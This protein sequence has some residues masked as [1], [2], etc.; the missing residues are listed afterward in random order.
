[1]EYVHFALCNQT[2]GDRSA[3]AVI[4][5]NWA[6]TPFAMHFLGDEQPKKPGSGDQ[7]ADKATDQAKD[8]VAGATAMQSC[9][10]ESQ[11]RHLVTWFEK[12]WEQRHAAATSGH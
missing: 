1:M 4:G 6:L 10:N 5:L 2:I 12:P 9:D 7:A 3:D 8:G 11:L